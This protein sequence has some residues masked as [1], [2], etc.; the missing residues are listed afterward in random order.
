MSAGGDKAKV[1]QDF[2]RNPFRGRISTNHHKH[3]MKQMDVD[4]SILLKQIQYLRIAV[5]QQSGGTNGQRVH[6]LIRSKN[7]H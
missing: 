1:Y 4:I 2:Q 3:N 5:S 7:I 6:S